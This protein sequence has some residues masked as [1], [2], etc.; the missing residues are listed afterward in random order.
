[1]TWSCHGL[2]PALALAPL[3]RRGAIAAWAMMDP[4]LPEA[5]EIPC[6]VER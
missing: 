6:D 5:A 1:M 2:A 3:V 4:I